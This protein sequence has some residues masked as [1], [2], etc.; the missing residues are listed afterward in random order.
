MHNVIWEMYTLT[1]RQ[2]EGRDKKKIQ[3]AQ[4]WTSL[5]AGEV[6]LLG[7]LH[8][9]TSTERVSADGSSSSTDFTLPYET[10]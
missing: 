1:K 9:S 3:S 2:G 10:E 7:G 4:E 6:L 5:P 8:S